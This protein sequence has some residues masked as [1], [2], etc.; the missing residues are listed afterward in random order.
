[1]P[2]RTLKVFNRPIV[3]FRTTL[4]GTPT[5]RA[6][7]SSERIWRALNAGGEGKISSEEIPQGTLVRID[8]YPAFIVGPGD[9]RAHL[10]E[11]VENTTA[12]AIAALRDVIAETREARDGKRMLTNGL[13]A[14]G[15]IVVYVGLLWLLSRVGRFVTGRAMQLAND[16]AHR[17]QVGGVALVRRE[18]FLGIVRRVARA[19]YWLFV[20]LLTYEFLSFVL[21]LFPFTRPW[22]E[23]LNAFLISTTIGIV[24]A[25]ARALPDLMVAVVIF[26]LARAASQG[27]KSFF[28]GV[29][30]GRINVGWVDA[31]SARPTR[32]LAA[33]GI[34]VFAIA[35]AYPY[36]PGSDTDAFK[37]LS[38]LVGLMV[39]M[40]ASGLVGQAASGLI[41]MFTRVY[42]PGEYVRIG[43]NEGTITTMGTFT[44]QMRTGLG[45]ELTLPNTLV[46]SSVT[47]NYSRV[48]KGDGFILD[49]AIT[50]G[51]DA[52]WRQV[53]AMLIEAADRTEGILKSPAPRVFQT[54]LSDFYVEYRLVCEALAT[55]PRPR[56]ELLSLLHGAIQDVFNEY[57]VQIMSP[58][59]LA[60]PEQAKVVPPDQWH[61]PPAAP[62]P[63][64]R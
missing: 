52:P 20:L 3:T 18:R 28:D 39:S 45:E 27:M 21:G 57:G 61:A 35:M 8:N 12:S 14:G 16:K 38:V 56:A 42:R 4:F 15:A 10:G 13:W 49:T 54:A 2:A 1:M 46:M 37:G 53:Q 11:T 32:R 22:A 55:E 36:I 64:T 25:I 63:G 33:F 60:D 58:H 40:G 47:R 29:Q 17:L 34:W 44:T 62:G 7:D 9:V 43:D 51:Y 26:V 23:G 41:L 19:G 5:E 50:I 24:V 31:D 6:A 59:Y 30:A 48:A